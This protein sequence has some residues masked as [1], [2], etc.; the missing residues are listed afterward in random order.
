MPNA[1]AK[2]VAEKVA[3]FDMV[4]IDADFADHWE[5]F[6]WAV[7]LTRPNGCI[8]FDDVI[9]S[10]FKNGQ[11]EIVE[12]SFLDKVGKDDR[13]KATLVPTVVSMYPVIETPVFNGFVL[14]TVLHH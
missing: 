8:F 11:A 4:F 7:K 6:D 10:M 9:A 14:A 5:H 2:L 12:G 13:V 3:P 1:L